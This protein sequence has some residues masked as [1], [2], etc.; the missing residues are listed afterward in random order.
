MKLYDEK[1]NRL[2]V[3]RCLAEANLVNG[4]LLPILASWAQ[5]S[6]D[7]RLRARI[8][9]ACLEILVPL[10][11]PL[12][13]DQ[14]T[15]NHHRHSPYIQQAQI[16]Y[17]A[18]VLGHDTASI[19]RIVVQIGLPAI[20]LPRRERS[21]R[22]EGIIK[23]ILYF[24][25]NIAMIC[26][27]PGL[28]SQGL[29]T[30]ISRSATIEAFKFQDVFALLLTLSSNM[31]EDFDL[32]DVIVLDILFHLVRG[33]EVQKLFMNDAQRKTHQISELRDVLKQE[34]GMHRNYKKTAP[35]R[36]G[37]FGT[38][39][40]VK[41]GEE[42]VSTVSG[43]D[44]LKAGG[45]TL[46]KM[47]KAKKF[48][49]PRQQKE[50]EAHSSQ[51]FDRFVPLTDSAVEFLRVFVEEF[52][53]S[54]FNP[55]FIHLR[56]A[57]EREADRILPINYRQYFYVV[58]WFLE[59]ER[60]RRTYHSRIRQINKL[61]TDFEADSYGLVAGVLNQEMFITLNRY[62]QLSLDHR[63]WQDLN[64]S[65]RCFTQIL[66]T[67]Q[68]M[69]KSS[70]EEDQEI[71]DNIQN[72]IFYEETTH[73]R[74][75]S[76]LRE[77]Q[78]KGLG[79]LDAATNLSHV[80]LRMLE[81]YSKENVDLQ[82][83]S[84][85]RARQK[86]KE[87]ERSQNQDRDQD[88]DNLTEES[89]NE[90]AVDAA[91]VSRERKFDFNRF[92]AKF[93]TQKAVDAFV[94][95]TKH[96][97]DLSE[98]QLKRAHRFFYRVAFKQELAVL[99]FRVD[100][101]ALFRRMVRSPEGLHRQDGMF[102]EWEELVRQVFRRLFKK[103]DERP[104][105]VVEMLFSKIRS[106]LF[107]LEYGHEKQTSSLSKGI[108]E[109][110]V[111]SRAKTQA[112]KIAIVIGA[113]NADDVMGPVHMVRRNLQMACDERK[114]WEDKIE[115]SERAGSTAESSTEPKDHTEQ[116]SPP[117]IAIK[118][119][120]DEDARA[121]HKR[122][123]VRLLLTVCGFE[124]AQKPSPTALHL[125]PPWL[126]PS[127]LSS[128]HLHDLLQSINSN[129]L[130]PITEFDGEEPSLL[131]RRARVSRESHDDSNDE[132][133]IRDGF[134]PRS[135]F[136]NDDSSSEGSETFAFPD[137]LRPR[138]PYK[139][140]PQKKRTLKRKRPS[141]DDDGNEFD[142]DDLAAQRRQ[143]REE[144]AL[145]RRRKIKSELYIRESDEEADEEAEAEFFR[146]EE[147]RRR[148][149]EGEVERAM[150]VGREEA[151]KPKAATTN[152]KGGT[153][154]E[155]AEDVDADVEKENN[156]SSGVQ[157]KKRKTSKSKK[158]NN[159]KFVP[160][161][162]VDGDDDDTDNADAGDEYDDDDV[163]VELDIANNLDN[164]PA[165][166]VDGH[167]TSSSSPSNDHH[168]NNSGT[169]SGAED[170]QGGEIDTPPSSS[171]PLDDSALPPKPDASA[172]LGG[173]DGAGTGAV[174]PAARTRRG[175]GRVR[176]GFVVDSDDDE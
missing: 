176:A 92:A 134:A 77:S 6:P 3:A 10:T 27:A 65:I 18:G 155:G 42:K 68:E 104:E 95:F 15:V 51:A 163:N 127:S 79:Y 72:R 110:E 37:R 24:L 128:S 97:R 5:G 55:L 29:E 145:E 26:Q 173:G 99:L 130:K 20:A 161:A 47:D 59:A 115:A 69:I 66:L 96:F 162:L 122:A 160:G 74:I 35:T 67:V 50:H 44:T 58:A 124:Q 111:N 12:E 64:A 76:I 36:H 14:M 60:A 157:R 126:I 120:N 105:L 112:E 117:P 16:L 153:G 49:K 75:V 156:G 109:L 135:A 53:D 100:I 136:I 33:V 2:D 140:K 34:S 22:D 63:Q 88:Q 81:R 118:P 89:E 131:I 38:M 132:M 129:I 57:I 45:Q 137:N 166:A 82:I 144:A 139:G 54:G 146:M 107:Y 171:P 141:R 142:E 73:D 21:T 125:P 30:E 147:L 4:D 9:L 7:D 28:P 85:R 98:E 25:R 80:F 133:F 113:L 174:P 83:R 164:V 116:P 48:N 41:R 170:A 159:T 158:K 11:W 61:Q 119:R 13:Q 165:T 93:T 168:N 90:D 151:G 143:A 87:R 84:R 52:L 123:K 32:Q 102:K 8:A 17:K 62:M 86:K 154:K 138:D 103:L 148:E 19:L 94:A 71:A 101:L 114:S 78:D 1:T 149:Q 70:I 40:W 43:Q 175:R 46:A 106:T 167:D 108:F 91:Q 23:L 169:T 121:M 56:K 31:G 150:M 172:K 152:G 39:I